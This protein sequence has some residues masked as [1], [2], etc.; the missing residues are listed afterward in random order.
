MKIMRINND[1]SKYQQINHQKNNKQNI[2]FTK[3][4]LLFDLEQKDIIKNTNTEMWELIENLKQ[5][6]SEDKIVD[7]S[8]KKYFGE[9]IANIIPGEEIRYKKGLD[10]I[11]YMKGF[12]ILD[13]N[14]ALSEYMRTS[15]KKIR[16]AAATLESIG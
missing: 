15:A 14:D 11:N 1:S 16:D 2:T 10:N 13:G 7:I 8:L 12:S 3:C 4:S 6:F 5:E 9:I